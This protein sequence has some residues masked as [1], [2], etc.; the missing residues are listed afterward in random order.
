MSNQAEIKFAKLISEGK[1]REH[2]NELEIDVE[3]DLDVEKLDL[4][5]SA[6]QNH[7]FSMFVTMLSGLLSLMYVPSIVK[8]LAKTGQSNTP[9]LSFRR[10]LRTL[11]NVMK[12]Y[13]LKPELRIKSLKNVRKIHSA[14]AKNHEMTQFDMVVTQWAFIAPALLRPLEIGNHKILVLMKTLLSIYSKC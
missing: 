2:D 14:V 10:Y 4:G 9:E 7:F 1:K 8:V 5:C 12:W 3:T 6:F 13:D 11:N